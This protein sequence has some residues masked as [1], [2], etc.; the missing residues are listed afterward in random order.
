MLVDLGAFSKKSDAIVSFKEAGMWSAVWVGLAIC[1]YFFLRTYGDFVHEINSPESLENVKN[2]LY[3]HLQFGEDFQQ[4]LKVFK[5]NM[6]L[7]YI[8]GYLVEYS[9]SV[10][11]IFV[12]ILIFN[13]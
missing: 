11:N 5:N 12:F 3:K 7:E 1:F 13:S 9:L 6:A 10:D 8:T 4:N 2:Q